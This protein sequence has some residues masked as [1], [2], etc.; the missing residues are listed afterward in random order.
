MAWLWRAEIASV[1]TLPLERVNPAL[2]LFIET[3][4]I[5]DQH[6]GRM[7]TPPTRLVIACALAFSCGALTPAAQAETFTFDGSGAGGVDV[8]ETAQT[9]AQFY[10]GVRRSQTFVPEDGANFFFHRDTRDDTLSLLILADRRN[11]GTSGTLFGSISNLGAGVTITRSDDANELQLAS[12][13]V[14]TF[15][16]RFNNRGI[17]GGVISG[18][19]PND[20]SFH[21][22]ITSATGLTSTNLVGTT[23]VVSLGVIPGAGVS[24]VANSPEPG[25]W[26]LFML[27]FAGL[28]FAGKRRRGAEINQRSRKNEGGRSMDAPVGLGPHHMAYALSLNSSGRTPHHC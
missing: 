25:A 28:A 7:R 26:A 2:T 6:I 16:F 23:G 21:L 15:S 9:G 20:V 14:A 13:G 4:N 10:N 24:F 22:D 11:D 5:S 19:N 1:R 18:L 27:S 8:F 3:L 12:P 17:D